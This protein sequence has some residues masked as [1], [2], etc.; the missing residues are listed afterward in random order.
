MPTQGLPE[1]G[2]ADGRAPHPNSDGA[3]CLR[4]TDRLAGAAARAKALRDA[5]ELLLQHDA[6]KG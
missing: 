2:L 3:G 1:I 4:A 6:M 5:A